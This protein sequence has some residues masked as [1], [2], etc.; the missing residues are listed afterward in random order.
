MWI[1]VIEEYSSLGESSRIHS[2]Y[3]SEDKVNQMVDTLKIQQDE[4]YN[5]YLEWVDSDSDEAESIP[6]VGDL[7][8]TVSKTWLDEAPYKAFDI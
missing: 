1:Y 5:K 3:V 8:Y 7:C 6:E 4:L 2:A